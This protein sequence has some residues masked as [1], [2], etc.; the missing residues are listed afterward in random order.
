[1]FVTS[2]SVTY[3]IYVLG[4]PGI[5]FHYY[6]AVYDECKYS[7]TFW[8]TDRTRLFVQY[9][10]LSSLY[11]LIWRHWTYKMLVRYILSSVWVRLSILSP[12]S[13]YT[14]C[15][16]VCFQFTHFPCD[17]WENIYTLSYYHHQIGSMNYYP[18]FR[19]RS[20]NN[21]VSCMSFYILKI[22]LQI[23]LHNTNTHM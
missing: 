7:D 9:I 1:M 3:C 13:I 21:G 14:I 6:C 20:W 2:Y 15:G 16:A 4:K 12:L 22:Q 5:C 18:L 10:S 11:K 23:K 17:D 8:L 19:V